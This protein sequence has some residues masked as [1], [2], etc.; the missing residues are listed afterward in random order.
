MFL[1]RDKEIPL[2]K[3]LRVALQSIFSIG[4]HKSVLIASKLGFS[5]PFFI[6]NLNAY[7]FSLIFFMLKK[8]TLSETRLRRIFSSTIKLHVDM[9]S[10]R[11]LRHKLFLPVRGQ[12]TRTNAG[13]RRRLRNSKDKLLW[14]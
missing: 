4:W 6:N 7:N 12:R 14:S 9:E 5:Y 1:F 10:Y 8:L 13:T 11:G 2:N 3:E